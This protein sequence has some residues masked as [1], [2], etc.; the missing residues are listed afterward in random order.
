MGKLPKQRR[1]QDAPIWVPS[2]KRS[3]ASK[4]EKARR[5]AQLEASRAR[6]RVLLERTRLGREAVTQRASGADMRAYAGLPVITGLRAKKPSKR[7]YDETKRAPVGSAAIPSEAFLGRMKD[8]PVLD[9]RRCSACDRIGHIRTRC[10][11]I[12][13]FAA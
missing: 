3:A 8:L 7:V 5:A 10:P 9:R 12:A 4:T 13:Q 6:R 1:R 2:G 11:G